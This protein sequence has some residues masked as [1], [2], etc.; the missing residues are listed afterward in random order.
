MGHPA[1]GYGQTTKEYGYLASGGS[2]ALRNSVV[3]FC[4]SSIDNTFTS[5]V[6]VC[7]SRPSLTMLI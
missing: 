4:S 2:K 1:S 6:T 5:P 7:T 3:A